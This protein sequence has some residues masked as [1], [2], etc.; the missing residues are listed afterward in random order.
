M[1][2]TLLDIFQNWGACA[3]VGKGIVSL[4]SR[5]ETCTAHV[6]EPNGHLM[7]KGIEQFQTHYRVAYVLTDS[8]I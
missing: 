2:H 6:A 7:G 3:G 5:A 4:P 8:T 1:L